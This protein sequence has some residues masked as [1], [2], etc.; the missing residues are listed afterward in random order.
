QFIPD[1]RYPDPIAAVW[2]KTCPHGEQTATFTRTITIP[3]PPADAMFQVNPLWGSASAS[4]G[5]NSNPIDWAELKVNGHLLLHRRLTSTFFTAQLDD[6]TVRHAFRF[7]AN[8][9]EVRVHRRALAAAVKSCNVGGKDF[10]HDPTHL[11]VQFALWGD[12]AAD[13]SFEPKPKALYKKFS[14]GVENITAEGSITFSNAGPSGVANGKLNLN[15]GAQLLAVRNAGDCT[16]APDTKESTGPLGD[17]F[18]IG[19]ARSR[20]TATC[21]ISLRARAGR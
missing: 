10:L 18:L 19:R 21:A 17:T 8:D 16:T 3:G 20:F 5:A 7:G 6:K 9:V 14:G 13:L 12:F 2:T 4:P 11:G 15:A 1:T